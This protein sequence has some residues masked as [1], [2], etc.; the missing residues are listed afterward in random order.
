MRSKVI[1]ATVAIAAVVV[2]AVGFAPWRSL[3][4]PVTARATE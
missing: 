1:M 3:M 4:G 2:V